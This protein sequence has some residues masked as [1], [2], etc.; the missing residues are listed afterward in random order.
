MPNDEPSPCESEYRHK[1]YRKLTGRKD[2]LRPAAVTFDDGSVGWYEAGWGPMMV[3]TPSSL[4]MWLDQRKFIYSG[5][6]AGGPDAR[7][8]GRRHPTAQIHRSELDSE[9]TF[10][11]K[12]EYLSMETEPGPMPFSRESKSSS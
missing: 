8:S 1:T 5:G 9:G 11:K 12:D 7:I 4:R 3:K 2:Q 6:R 10:V